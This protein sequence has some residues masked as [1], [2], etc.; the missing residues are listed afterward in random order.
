MTKTNSFRFYLNLISIKC[1]TFVLI[2]STFSVHVNSQLVGSYTIG[3]SNPN[4]ATLSDAVA[5]LNLNGVS[6]SVTFNLRAGEY[7]E[8]VSL[9]EI[10]G[11]SE[12]SVVTFQAEGNNA[13]DVT[14]KHD[15][16]S[17]LNYLFKLD[18]ADHI[19]VQNLTFEPT[20]TSYND[21]FRL[22][23]GTNNIKVSDC[24]FDGDRG[25]AFRTLGSTAYQ[26]ISIENNEFNNFDVAI[27]LGGSLKEV[28][29][30]NNTISNPTI[31]YNWAIYSSGPDS[32]FIESNI[33]NREGGGAGCYVYNCTD[34]DYKNNEVYLNGTGTGLYLDRIRGNGFVANNAISTSGD[35]MYFY[36]VDNTE[37]YFNSVLTTDV[38]G[39]KSAIYHRYC[40]NLNLKNNIFSNEGGRYAM[41]GY[42]IVGLVSDYNNFYSTTNNFINWDG[43]IYS[44]LQS[45]QMV[46]TQDS[47]SVAS[48][49]IF[50]GPN[51]L[52]SNQALLDG[53]GIEISNVDVDITGATRS[54]P[55]DIGAYEFSAT[56]DNA[57]ILSLTPEPYFDPDN[58]PVAIELFNSGPSI[59]TSVLLNWS[60]NG[61]AQTSVQW[62]GNLAQNNAENVILG[63]YQFDE[64]T[65]YEILVWLS[66][67]NN[68]QDTDA[69]DDT[70]LVS[71][72]YTRLSGDYTVGGTNPDFTSLVEAQDALNYG[73]MAGPVRLL[74]RS[75]EYNEQILL[76]EIDG[77]S[78]TNTL[79]IQSETN[80]ASDVTIT[81]ESSSS[82][83]YLI[84]L[85]GT[86]NVIITDLTFAPSG[87]SYNDVMRFENSTDNIEVNNCIFNGN[88]GT[89]IFTSGSTAYQDIS[90]ENN[91]FNNF[92]V[93]I[94][95]SGSLK[96]VYI[97]NNA[98]SNP[99]ISYNWA[100]YSSGPDSLFIES[101]VVNRE[102][103]SSGCY[104]YSCTDVNFE[105]N[106]IY[107]NGVGTGLYLDRI[108]G[109]GLIVNN[110]ISTIGDGMYFYDV[111]ETEVY[112]NSVLTTDANGNKSAIY[113]RYCDNLNLKNNIFSNEGGRYAMF[114][115]SISGL[116][117]DYNNFY[118]T[119]NNFI[120][121]DGV[122]YPDLE[123][124]QM[125]SMQDSNSV[126]ANPVFTDVVDLHAN[127][128][129]IDGAGISISTINT[130]IT[131]ATRDDPPDMGAYEFTAMGDNA[132]ILALTPEPQFDPDTYPVIVELFNS[133]PS[134][135]SSDSIYWSVNGVDQTPILW[136]GNLNVNAS[137]NVTLGN[138]QFDDA[139]N[140]EILV[141]S[142]SPNGQQ[143]IDLSDDTLLVENL[144]TTLSGDYTVGGDDPNFNT[145]TEA[146][147]ALNYGGIAGSVN[148]LIR[149]G[150]YEEQIVLSEIAGSSTDNTITIQSESEIADSVTIAYNAPSNLNYQIK[151]DG[152][153][154]VIIK[155][156]TFDPIGNSY[157]YVLRFEN[158]TNNVEV[159]N[160]IFNGNRG[161][162]ISTSGSE[163]YRNITI[164][165]NAFLNFDESIY[166]TGNLVEAYVLNNT[167]RD[168]I[169]TY[170]Y[171]IQT[172]GIDSIYIHSNTINRFNNGSGIY[173]YNTIYLSVEK[174]QIY[175]TGPRTGLYF[176]RIDAGAARSEIVNNFVSTNGDGF[177]FYDVDDMNVY[178]N[179]VLCHGASNGN[180]TFYWRYS[181]N[182]NVRN[183]IFS[184]ESGNDILVGYNE[185]G[186]ILDYN[187]YYTT[188][189][190]FGNWVNTDITDLGTWQST[191][192]QDAN[193]QFL[194]PL[195][196]DND[197]LHTNNIALSAGVFIASVTDDIDGEIRNTSQPFMG[198]DESPVAF[199]DVG[200]LEIVSP[201]APFPQGTNEIEIVMLN[202]FPTALNSATINW[203]VNNDTMNQIN[204]TGN[205]PSGETDTVFISTYQFDVAEPY[206][207]Q[208]WVSNPNGQTDDYSTNDT[209]TVID[210]YAAL[211]GEYTIGPNNADFE[212]LAQ[213]TE[214]LER[215][216]VVGEVIFNIQSGTYQANVEINEIL[217]SSL[218]NYIIFQSEAM[219]S[220]AVVLMD[221]LAT[222]SSSLVYLDSMDNVEF[223]YLTF[224]QT[225]NNSYCIRLD[226]DNYHVNINNCHFKIGSFGILIDD[227]VD[228]LSLSQNTFSSGTYGVYGDN[229]Y[230]TNVI[231]EENLF[232]NQTNKSIYLRYFISP[233]IRS[234]TVISASIGNAIELLSLRDS[235]KVVSNNI[236]SQDATRGIR[237][238]IGS[239]SAS[240]RG[241]V[242]NN[243]IS[244]NGTSTT[245]GIDYSGSYLDI[246]HNNVLV[247]AMEP[248]EGR[249]INITGSNN[250]L[251]NNIFANTGGGYCVYSSNTST[252]LESDY[253]NFY[254][255]NGKVGYWMGN[256]TSFAN[257]Q[258]GSGLDTNSFNLDPEFNSD[259]DLHINQQL[260]SSKG[261]P[262]DGLP[263]DI[264]G[265]FRNP[266]A[267]DIG[268][269]EFTSLV[270][271]VGVVEILSP[272]TGCDLPANEQVTIVVKNPGSQAQS[273]FNVA[274][275]L[276]DNA[277][278][279]E[280]IN[281]T[282]SPG[283]SIEY[284]F[285]STVTL[286][287]DSLYTLKAYTLLATDELL[288]NDT[289]TTSVI[290]YMP[291]NAQIVPASTTIDYGDTLL[292]TASGGTSYIWSGALEGE[293]PFSPT[294]SVAPFETQT[295]QV[296][297][298]DDNGCQDVQS[299]TISVTGTTG[300]PDLEVSNVYSGL[301][302]VEPGDPVTLT[303]DI[304]NIGDGAAAVDWTERIYFQSPDGYNRTLIEQHVYLESSTLGINEMINRSY[305]FD[306]PEELSIGDQG[307][308]VVELVPN[309]LELPLSTANNTAIE[310]QAW[311]IVRILSLSLNTNEIIEGSGNIYCTVTRSGS[312]N[313]SLTVNIN[314]SDADRFNFP[315][316]VTINAGQ[317]GRTFY[318]YTIDNDELEGD[319][320]ANITA[321]ASNFTNAQ[322]TIL[323]IDDEIPTVNIENL[324]TTLAEG[325]L[326]SFD[327]TT[328]FPPTDTLF[329]N[330]ISSN[331]EDVPL[332]TPVY[333]LPGDNSTT[334]EVLL[335]DDDF[336]EPNE[337]I[338]ITAG[339]AG[340]NSGFGSFILT[341]DE[342]I[343]AISFEI[344]VDTISESAGLY[345]TQGVITRLGNTDAILQVNISSDDPDALYMPTTV[346]LGPGEME[347]YFYIGIFDNLQNEGYR[348]I[349][350]T[351]SVLLAACN[352]TA[353]A[354]SAGV[355]N[356]IL[357]VVDDDGPTLTLT[358]S[359]LSLL[360]GI[361]NAGTLTITR[362]TATDDDLVVTLSSSDISELVLPLSI[363]IPAGA[364]SIDVP[365]TGEIDEE[366]DGNQQVTIQAEAAGF[367][368]GIVL[369]I[370]TD[371]NK[372][373]FEIVEVILPNTLIPAL[374]PFPFRA[375]IT[376][377]GFATAPS[378]A[379]L[380]GYLSE[381][382]ILDENDILVGTYVIDAPLVVGDT[383]EIW[384]V[385][386]APY[387]AGPYYLIFEI[388][389]ES[390]L[391]EIQYI[392]N[393][394][395]AIALEIEPDY[396]GTAIVDELTYLQGEDI[397][398]YGSST[399]E[400]G[401]PFPNAELELY[402]ITGS[403]RQEF[404]VTTDENGNY[405]F[406]FE[407]LASDA[408]HFVVGASFPGMGAEVVQDE[409]DILGIEVNANQYLIW[410]VLLNETETGVISV[411]N[412]SDFP[413]TNVS[414]EA[415][416]LP[417]G[418]VLEFD[419]IPLLQ[420][421][422]TLSF[423]Y[424]L[425]GT[426]VSPIGDYQEIPL[427]ISSD[428]N[429]IYELTGYY[430]CQA[431]EGFIS[432]EIA[433][434]Y[435]TISQ[436]Q[437]NFLEFRIFNNGVGET[438]DITVDMPPVD[439]MSLVSLE[440]I[441][442]LDSG[443]TSLVI[444]EF[445][446]AESLPLNTPASG[447]IVINASNGNFL[448]IP[449]TV[450]KVSEETGGIIVDV[451]DQY[452]YFT[453]EAPHVANASVKISHYFT[454][455][456]FAEGFTD[457]NG[458]FEA[459][460]L[461]EG[462][463][464]IVVQA[465]QHEGYNSTINILPGTDI[466]ETIFL[467]YQAISFTWD[468]VP[469]EIEDVYQIDLVMSFETNVP[470]PVVTIEVPDT[471]PQLFG[472]ETFNFYATLT[473]HGLITARDV[474]LNFPT[475]NPDYE[476]ITNYTPADLLAQQAIQVPVVMQRKTMGK[477]SND[478]EEDGDI[479]QKIS[480]ELNIKNYPNNN[481]NGNK[482]SNHCVGFVFAPH[483]YECGE[484]GI[485]Q[486][487]GE[488][489]SIEGEICSNGPGG[490]GP[491]GGGSGPITGTFN[492][493][494]GCPGGS[495]N[496][497]NNIPTI[498][499]E[500][501]CNACLNSVILAAA[502]CYPPTSVAG[503]IVSIATA[504]SW[505]NAIFL[506]APACI[507]KKGIGCAYGI[508]T[509]I[510]TCVF[511]PLLGLGGGSNRLAYTSEAL[512]QLDESSLSPIVLLTIDDL[513][514][515]YLAYVANNDYLEEHFGA[516]ADNENLVAFITAVGPFMDEQLPIN[517]T[518]VE[519]IKLELQNYDIAES[520]IDAFVARWNQTQEAWSQGIYIPNT[521][522]PNIINQDSV[523][524]Y[525]AQI[526]SVHDYALS[527]GYSSIEEM[528]TESLDIIIEQGESNSSVCSTV[529][530]QISQQLTM[531]R[532]AF[533]GTLGVVNGHPTDA[534]D[535]LFLNLEILNPEGVLS[536]DLFQI[537]VIGLN[538]LTGID[539]TGVLNAQNEG[540]ATILFIPEPGAA[541]TVPISYSF[542][543]SVS[544]LDPFSGLMVTV[545]LIPA[546]LQV[547]PSPDLYLHYFMQRDIYGDD[548]LTESIEPIIPAELA[549]MVENNGYGTAMGVVIESS[550]PEIVDNE[551]GL[552][553][554]FSLIGSNL[555]GQPANMGL[556][557]I[558]FGDISPL[559]TKIGQWYFTSSLLGHFVNYE[560]NLVHLSSYGNPDLSLI[561]GAE[562]HE[563][564]HSISVYNVDD[565]IDDFLVNEIQDAEETPDA[566]YLSQG[567]LI[568]D[569][570]PAESGE[571]T[572]NILA[573][574]NTNTLHVTPSLA[575][576]NYIK[577]DDPGNGNF[578]IV[579][580]TRSDGQEI[581]L[582]N[583]WLT[584][585][586]LPDSKEPIYEDKFHFAD[587]FT[588][589]D[590][591]T[592][593]VVWSAKDP[594]PPAVVSITGQPDQVVSEQ[595]E[596]LT[597]TFSEEIIEDSFDIDDLNLIV[598]SGDNIIDNTVI[599]T[600]IDS[601]T[602]E[603][604][605]SS[606]TTTDGY[607]VFTVQAAGV[608]DLTGTSGT[609]GEQVTWTQFLSVPAITEFIGIP[610]N[611][612]GMD[613]TSVQLM[614]NM[615]IDPVTFTID[616]LSIE[617]NGTS[618]NGDLVIT[619]VG[620]EN[621]LFE[622]TGIDSFIENDGDYE[623]FV[624]LTGIQAE[625]GTLGLAVQ[626]V[627]VT[628]DTKAPELTNLLP[629]IGGG[630]D[631]QHYTGADI[632]FDED[633][634][635]LDLVVLDLLKD[636]V[637]QNISNIVI[638]QVN[639]T[640][641]DIA[642]FGQLTYPEGNYTL[643][644][645][646][647]LVEDLAGNAGT[648]IEEVTWT[649]SRTSG[650]QI[651]N[652]SLSP[653]MG[654]SSTDGITNTTELSISF[655]INQDAS[656]IEIY[657]N[658]IGA[659][660]LLETLSS[661]TAGEIN[662]LVNLETGGNTVLEIKVI[663]LNGN[664][665]MENI[666][667]YI[668]QAALT[669][670]WDLIEGSI[671][672]QH[673]DTVIVTFSDRLLNESDLQTALVLYY[674]NNMLD[675]SGLEIN[676]LSLTDFAITGIPS[677][678]NAA[679][680]YM[681]GVDLTLL[682]KYSS[683]ISGNDVNSVS[684][685]IEEENNIVPVANA[686]QDTTLYA[687]TSYTLDGSGSY[688][689][690]GDSLSF[691]WYSPEGIVLDD[692]TSATPVLTITSELYGQEL[693]FLLSVSDGMD[694]ST[695][696]VVISIN[697]ECQEGFDECGICD[698]PGANTWYED[699]DSD[700]LGNPEI[701]SLSCDQP[702]GFVS[703][704]DDDDDTIE[705]CP[706][707]LD[708]CGVCDGPGANTWYEDLD[709]DGLGNPAVDSLSCDQPDGFVSNSDDLNDDCSEIAFTEIYCNANATLYQISF[710]FI[711]NSAGYGLTNNLTGE[712]VS[713]EN[714]YYTTEPFE[715]GTGYSFTA[716]LLDDPDC[717]MEFFSN[718]VDCITTN[719]ELLS[720]R[721][722]VKESGNLIHWS[723]AT[724]KGSDYFQL[725]R[726]TDGINFRAIKDIKARGNA[727]TI[728]DYQYLDLDV[729]A[730]NYYYRIK[731]V[732]EERTSKI[733]SDIIL[734]QRMD[735][736]FEIT[737]VAPIPTK[738]YLN[739]E[740]TMIENE[741]IYY[742]IYDVTGKLIENQLLNTKEG[743][744]ILKLDVNTYSGGIY[745]VKINSPKHGEAITRFIKQ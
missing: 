497:G 91:E 448:T 174:N 654:F 662:A 551:K 64:I 491:S 32:L 299:V 738:D 154:N 590:E 107:L 290:S 375:Y 603:V 284:T 225:A 404:L 454:G 623:L 606:V 318:I 707:G 315:S 510:G 458:L 421:N 129:L 326:L 153:D 470:M 640:W 172:S 713:F 571:F 657:Q 674:E 237:L 223:R 465:E 423:N 616:D 285:S 113:H 419:T 398:I 111:N 564:I 516:L 8:Q 380:E 291:V 348:D 11:A 599:I 281:Q 294:L 334:A 554:D 507:S 579:S 628:I 676:A 699:L 195:F 186:L 333:I 532:E 164:S 632:N 27:N 189:D 387:E 16:S 249:A 744:N 33:I 151:L 426:E 417:N 390:I 456:I 405:S 445:I 152:T 193:S 489:F 478:T 597:V 106:E 636:G 321:S 558:D 436:T 689:A 566:I 20:S 166:L 131:G 658:D 259:T 353:S 725:E 29:I 609:V 685:R 279:I 39:N 361:A 80:M 185:T 145:L 691:Q 586:T 504:G 653:D 727:N 69:S 302:D 268:A 289:L 26:D 176:D 580:V 92:D 492:G 123:S 467:S 519:S 35:G 411:K 486:Q 358:A 228:H 40:D 79:T 432:A 286:I 2:L 23:N 443:D 642:D 96:E 94:N 542:G 509:T 438:G 17:S 540:S 389:P 267:P 415:L 103:G 646:M 385:A 86:D 661:V 660:T 367:N 722:E 70:L 695:D 143:D 731:E 67:P 552:A 116:V 667:L 146:Q 320:N 670:S 54:N 444:I 694:I 441:P 350:I 213:A 293:N 355:F 121:W 115:Y 449:Y 425:T 312:T 108:T 128:S 560:T 208:F 460:G 523:A 188:G 427:L 51:D 664:S 167:I 624:D 231:I 648:G 618:A 253:N 697:A 688:D 50:I 224:E 701:D 592:Y 669:A 569:V 583:A 261:T 288:F 244:I 126:N 739:L 544:Y 515:V 522:Y 138:Y 663:D 114:G 25:V 216:G 644:V 205:I 183:N 57:G 6:G 650:L 255:P 3:G 637:S 240:N 397:T 710:I 484:N 635:P 641:Y 376:N 328:N 110:A 424:T 671:L 98:I 643:R 214:A 625:D 700:G 428:E 418:V 446:P 63:N 721:G 687:A 168:T 206:D 330:I 708:E 575:G 132:G 545:P 56:G 196:S 506:A 252:I 638:T 366:V 678:D 464:R 556:N 719:V 83:N 82:K 384:D 578:E 471:M 274:F 327:I 329:V 18:G 61:M 14:I 520:E 693:S 469:T 547:N 204:W 345:A 148:L 341:N 409:F 672:E 584:H 55:P 207:L 729:T 728:K 314:I 437:S 346:P 78:S 508:G 75:G 665:T 234:N 46:S 175:L 647:S 588:D 585:V 681:L 169:N 611:N 406:V 447:S 734:L 536:N 209:L 488:M 316:Q 711:P 567:N 422:E 420:G 698:G 370:V 304:T 501:G 140:Y 177:F 192:M 52:H 391:T 269:D 155:D 102:G 498:S 22:E 309:I 730:G 534:I 65:E 596:V 403:I 383:L 97:L 339:S 296:E 388:N 733:I 247:T 414:I 607:Y 627:L 343:P 440:V 472:T 349:E 273:N 741:S 87:S 276:G 342:D 313:S 275:Q 468:V 517:S 633:V 104:V 724:E 555:Q 84:R 373:D 659:L 120:N 139:T 442:S 162:A 28:Y 248:T 368:S 251:K 194:N 480:E 735:Y 550:Q 13:E 720:F 559:S 396:F 548:P 600:Q 230:S 99:T 704:S 264:D 217:G 311:N 199:N 364:A 232:L 331:V 549:V 686:G 220:S 263:E 360:E 36:D 740:F 125:V 297:V 546:T 526:E 89:A 673:P 630:L 44:D 393:I 134:V 474:E 539:G 379:I 270:D 265:D 226:S 218:D 260:L 74:L 9:E 677:I 332:P 5:D 365:L 481:L 137:E 582:K 372:P 587:D 714:S 351:A 319:I 85:N 198:A 453:D 451:V 127:Q 377:T 117:S 402:I 631:P 702:D 124:Y 282:I 615:P 238:T 77:I 236:I 666:S 620:T 502:G 88:R 562:L 317:S 652:L 287:Q 24:I 12:S 538:N 386:V 374:E 679:G 292:L 473:N 130:D 324:P 656:M 81:H 136:T 529:S 716:F 680:E 619:P 337:T 511:V 513:N 533:E 30:L 461:P 413:L 563:L 58:Y 278:V 541:P 149:N 10:I 178:H 435:R 718:F 394:S 141:W 7:N 408:G 477:A 163:L 573:A 703:N 181:E 109:S 487:A 301:T 482:L 535:S 352:C 295:Y 574:G 655:D 715:S 613:W 266:V 709:S 335:P 682:E 499:T 182:L 561:S 525:I 371:N 95:L 73:G 594:S 732:D 135:L 170:G 407:P 271:N 159:S 457:A 210:I 66:N 112:Y 626:S 696:V 629:F 378:G 595:V 202:N 303:F 336:A 53:T 589:F 452:T 243:F 475:D 21:V 344:T 505:A 705:S 171:G 239:S 200:L 494:P 354:T 610:D 47:N 4:Y 179:S 245:Y 604:D 410:E 528:H 158:S 45:Y 357:T 257:W 363:T 675:I 557:N 683:G 118:S 581:P 165:D 518:D 62:T 462:V 156:L 634:M 726:S 157:N 359:P 60:V 43:A 639:P 221:S 307:V 684:W 651:S 717:S 577:L 280:S 736:K 190:V 37:V 49:P 622:L 429:I 576:W 72:L 621:I 142:S 356:D 416:S 90:I 258:S 401:A 105:N 553:I 262:V 503:C 233:I 612:T 439:F 463:L 490:S 283:L 306:L 76:N 68:Q 593:T 649:V 743:V 38:N 187:N 42:S 543:G 308:F 531:T 485:W 201:T 219:D 602:Y 524:S 310:N 572:G 362:N 212:T 431:Q 197:D 41:F 712:T 537:E 173:T 347:K 496:S 459:D 48:N 147:D 381:D 34:I 399:N 241:L 479:I 608:Q 300:L 450:E 31:S 180:R 101:N 527:R 512:R 254:A 514:Q 521:T 272:A 1:L 160:C 15:A 412:R 144:Y 400:D 227:F 455:E 605:I 495:P 133:G 601:V 150:V 229:N 191:T 690:D 323:L 161:R 93:A 723:V 250:I 742:N 568:Y 430:F 570:F 737:S 19:V 530:I 242:G 298:T 203:V 122:V 338:N 392:N 340:L 493:C 235:F 369:V 614:F 706:E 433:S 322:E 745:F 71:N 59:L 565:G 483:W 591:V 645:D 476:W 277:P 215:G 395:P 100:I 246:F 222:S 598:Q 617:Y 668:D 382:I 256:R 325:E 500:I 184:N 692:E 466:T 119:T 434:I 211:I 305:T